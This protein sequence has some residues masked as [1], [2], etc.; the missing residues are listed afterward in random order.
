MLKCRLRQVLYH[1][2]LSLRRSNNKL[3]PLK[4]KMTKAFLLFRKQASSTL[5]ETNKFR[6]SPVI[7]AKQS[8]KQ[9]NLRR[10]KSLKAATNRLNSHSPTTS[11]HQLVFRLLI[12][13]ANQRLTSSHQTRLPKRL[14]RLSL[15]QLPRKVRS[16]LCLA[17]WQCRCHLL[18]SLHLSLLP[19]KIHLRK[20][21]SS[22]LSPKIMSKRSS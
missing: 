18:K 21:L 17:C 2:L 22:Y 12:R 8:N 7:S 13:Q 6:A 11:N 9:I 14:K 4:T 16:R 19:N 15:K 3:H 20:S 10:L 5:K 1:L